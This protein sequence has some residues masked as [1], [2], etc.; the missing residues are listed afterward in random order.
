MFLKILEIFFFDAI[1]PRYV[2]CI[3]YQKRSCLMR[4]ALNAFYVYVSIQ[5]K[6]S[7]LCYSVFLFLHFK[8]QQING[9]QINQKVS[10]KNKEEHE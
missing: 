10:N 8:M 7:L 6:E 3:S 9:E 5:S 2:L 1:L 4:N